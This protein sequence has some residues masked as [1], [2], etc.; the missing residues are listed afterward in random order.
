M[1][2]TTKFALLL[3]LFIQ[4]AV[5]LKVLMYS[6]RFGK[7]HVM[8]IGKLADQLAEAGH[9]IVSFLIEKI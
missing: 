3:L 9:E 8:F 4:N 7:S 6:P 1:Q 5:S 2:S